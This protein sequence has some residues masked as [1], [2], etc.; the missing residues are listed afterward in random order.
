MHLAFRIA[1]GILVAFVASLVA[2]MLRE[3]AANR[4]FYLDVAT[5]AQDTGYAAFGAMDAPLLSFRSAT[6]YLQVVRG[7]HAT[8]IALRLAPRDLQ[9]FPDPAWVDDDLLRQVLLGEEGDPAGMNRV[10]R[11]RQAF[12]S[13]LRDHLPEMAAAVSTADPVFE[14]AIARAR[15]ER[16]ARCQRHSDAVSAEAARRR[17]G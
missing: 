6:S 9:R 16:D 14:A 8:Y 13:F 4:R 11:D 7:G 12:V 3:G 2:V 10:W 17:A 15:E 5:I 1:I